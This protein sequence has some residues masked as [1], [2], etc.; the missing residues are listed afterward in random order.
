MD[1]THWNFTQFFGAAFACLGVYFFL[2]GL[3]RLLRRN[4]EASWSKVKG[5]IVV[6]EIEF[7]REIY[8]AKIRYT[9]GFDGQVHEGSCIAPLQAW[10]SFRSTAARFVDRYPVGRDADVYVDPSDPG[11]SV[12]EPQQQPI[13]AITE[14]LL[15]VAAGGFGYFA[16]LTASV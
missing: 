13:A 12:L 1:V 4:P 3:V 11:C 2:N 14:T 10:S 9:Y 6:S 5:K 15:G 8:R 16:W 7:S